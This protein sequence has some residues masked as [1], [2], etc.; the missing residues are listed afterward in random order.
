MHTI[1]LC[2]MIIVMPCYSLLMKKD[3]AYTKV[4]FTNSGSEGTELATKVVRHLN[5]KD[6][7]LLRMIKVI[8]VPFAGY[9]LVD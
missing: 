1:I 8:M 5:N 7:K 6:K 9:Q 4:F 2:I 3:S